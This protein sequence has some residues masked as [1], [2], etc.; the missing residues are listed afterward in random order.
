MDKL[1]NLIKQKSFRRGAFT[2]A[3]GAT[4][5][6]FFD[7]K[8]TMLHPLGATL[9]A[10]RI[11]RLIETYPAD[12]V[13][14]MALGA[15]PIIGA[16]V[17]RSYRSEKPLPGCYV[18]KEVKDHGTQQLIEGLD[19]NGLTVILVEDVTTTGGS[20]LRAATAVRAAGGIVTHAITVVDRLEGGAG[21]LAD[22]GIT[23]QALL[24][25]NDFE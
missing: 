25:R 21:H 12:A 16:V 9:I 4:S 20:L 5:Q 2:L 19:V 6:Y 3:S 10:E 8:P 7:L 17:A 24:A 13:G 1:L 15:V 23:L 11:V 14:G 22:H 18:R